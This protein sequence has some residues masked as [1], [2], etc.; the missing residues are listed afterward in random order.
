MIVARGYFAVGLWMPRDSK[1]VAHALRACG[2]FGA[3]FLAYSGARYRRDPVDTQN[4]WRHMPL[5][6][7]GE[8]PDHILDVVPHECVPVAVEITDSAVPLAQYK[9]PERAYYVFGPEDGSISTAVM[10]K[11]RDVVRI[12]SRFCLNLAAAVNV[13]LYDRV[14]KSTPTN[15]LFA[16]GKPLAVEVSP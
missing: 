9:H 16:H 6:N 4:A 2:C 1:N 13:V 11:C 15:A 7:A 8:T 12:P 14:A 5:L 3:A 10:N